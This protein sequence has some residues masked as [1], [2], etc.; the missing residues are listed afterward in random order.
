[1]RKPGTARF[2]PGYR[3][4]ITQKSRQKHA[5][6]PSFAFFSPISQVCSQTFPLFPSTCKSTFS[7][8][9]KQLGF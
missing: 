3:A 8:F 2:C 7:D 6:T 5:K 1:V 4:Q 9:E